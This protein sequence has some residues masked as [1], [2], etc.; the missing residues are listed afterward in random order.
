MVPAEITKGREKHPYS[1]SV[2]ADKADGLWVSKNYK[3]VKLLLA[4][5][6]QYLGYLQAGGNVD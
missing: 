3:L 1:A 2:K 5:N 4:F 6:K